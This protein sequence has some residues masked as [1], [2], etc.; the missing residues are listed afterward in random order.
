M[1]KKCLKASVFAEGTYL[2]GERE[3]RNKPICLLNHDIFFSE[4]E[5]IL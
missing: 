1:N 2:N 3:T 5:A 4:N